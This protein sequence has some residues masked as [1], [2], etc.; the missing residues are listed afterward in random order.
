MSVDRA[1]H[2]GH[3]ARIRGDP[4][5][6]QGCPSD[7]GFGDRPLCGSL[8]K[9]RE[10]SPCKPVVGHLQGVE[11]ESR[12][13]EV[14][15]AI[16]EAAPAVLAI[17]RAELLRDGTSPPDAFEHGRPQLP[18]LRLFLEE[19]WRLGCPREF[20][21]KI[22]EDATLM[23]RVRSRGESRSQ[24][25]FVDIVAVGKD[26]GF[27]FTVEDLKS[28]LTEAER[29]QREAALRKDEDLTAVAGAGRASGSVSSP[30]D[31]TSSAILSAAVSGWATSTRRGFGR[32]P[33]DGFRAR[34][35]RERYLNDGRTVARLT[36]R[37]GLSA[38]VMS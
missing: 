16:A 23:K 5:P 25:R 30:F 9:N 29:A 34:N 8:L 13:L 12:A 17:V 38:V 28:L 27:E 14:R 20:L 33:F 7:L 11:E 10:H 1:P 24:K 36:A 18:D 22:H 21:D 3:A 31:P 4:S 6:K 2:S 35:P 15:P 19:T 32:H 37:A 26:E